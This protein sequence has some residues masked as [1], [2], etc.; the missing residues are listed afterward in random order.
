MLMLNTELT[1]ENKPSLEFK[2]SNDLSEFSLTEC[3]ETETLTEI[4][5][6]FDYC[7]NNVQNSIKNI[8]ELFGVIDVNNFKKYENMAKSSQCYF[9]MLLQN[10][11]INPVTIEGTQN[12]NVLRTL[13]DL[14]TKLWHMKG[15]RLTCKLIWQ[16][17]RGLCFIFN[18]K[19]YF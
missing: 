16:K 12:S 10:Y 11:A 2:L 7:T 4:L 8:C 18:K 15:G 9:G 19:I 13:A 17:E 3:L 6:N 5:K 1:D 14:Q